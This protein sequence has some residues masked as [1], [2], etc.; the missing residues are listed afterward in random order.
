MGYERFIARR[1]LT[2]RR[3]QAFVSVITLI[4]TVGIAI[5]VAALIIAIALITGFQKDVQDKILGATSHL[6]I[7][8][9]TGDGLADYAGTA[10]LIRPVAGVKSVSPVVYGN[11]LLQ[12]AD[13]SQGAILKG[14]DLQA[15]RGI[16]PWLEVLESGDLP[17]EGSGP[18][19]GILLGRDLAAAMGAAVG[20][21]VTVVTTS[22]KLGPLGISP[23]FRAFRVTG[24]FR[25]GLY[26][27]DSTTALA[28]LPS[29]QKF[30]GTGDRISYLQVMIEDIFAADRLKASLLDT[31]PPLVYITTWGE[32]NQ[33]LFSALEL[34]KNIIFLTITLIVI[35]AAL[36][37]IATLILMV[38]EKTRDIG[39]LMALGATPAEVRR[40]FFMQGAM[41]GIVGTAV[42]TALGLLWCLAA[43]TFELIRVPVDIYQ[44][45]Y[46]PFRITPLDL[47]LIV[48]VSLSISLVSTLFPSHRAAKTD[49]VQALK[50]E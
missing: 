27:F 45:S 24:T 29:A 46:V 14:M 42:G 33:S 39:I 4:S 41:I 35:V 38:M 23:K 37:I 16:Q 25:T 3:K 31:L 1:Y 28:R 21:I 2:A 44:I 50:Y 10:N 12:A 9:L 26:E 36:N 17:E 49:P 11:V 22:S 15:E 7:S 18:R 30:F 8:D 48:G 34:E 40:I 43:N 20:D 32:L 6:M 19:E 13:K 5:G 47:L